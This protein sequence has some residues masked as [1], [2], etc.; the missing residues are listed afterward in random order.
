MTLF[1]LN[2]EILLMVIL[3]G[4]TIIGY[5]I[6]INAQGTTRMSLSYLLATVL[7]AGTALVI[8]QFV[9]GQTSQILEEE[10]LTRLASEKEAMEQRLVE[11]GTAREELQ[12]IELR[13]DEVL[14]VQAIVLDAIE[15]AEV[16]ATMNM[17]DYTLTIDQKISKAATIKRQV[18]ALKTKYSTIESNLVYTQNNSFPQA[19]E[20]LVKSSLYCKLYYTA[21]DS[22]QEG[23]REQVMRT[24]AVAA[25]RLLNQ[26]NNQL[27]NMKS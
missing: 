9:N 21:E 2:V 16:L 11:S 6:A 1:E 17:Q 26:F 18:Q 13:N 5:M 19:I 7:L 4:I 8:V 27:E 24:N 15:I 23:T 20:K 14:E 22:E 3:V 12:E 25:K 10:Y